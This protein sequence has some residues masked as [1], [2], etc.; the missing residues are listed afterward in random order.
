[1]SGSEQTVHIGT[2][3]STTVNKVNS[4]Y[5][6]VQNDSKPTE[7]TVQRTAVQNVYTVDST[8]QSVHRRRT[9]QMSG[10][11]YSVQTN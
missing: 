6:T 10:S 3:Q 2:V 1:M 8:V 4:T 11:E 5:G 7:R 9:V